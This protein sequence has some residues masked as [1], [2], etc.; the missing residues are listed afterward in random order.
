[1]CFALSGVVF[2]LDFDPSF[3]FFFGFLVGC[4]LFIYLFKHMDN[5]R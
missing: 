4:F 1:V 5:C 2:C 3:L